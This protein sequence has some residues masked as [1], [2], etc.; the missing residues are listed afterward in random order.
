MQVLDAEDER[1]PNHPQ[2][3]DPSTRFGVGKP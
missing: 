2:V 3:L 1:S